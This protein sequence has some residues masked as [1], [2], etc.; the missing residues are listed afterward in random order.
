MRVQLEGAGGGQVGP[1]AILALW[2]W[3]GA[4][5]LLLGGEEEYPPHS[6]AV[7]LHELM[8]KRS[9]KTV[10]HMLCLCGHYD[11]ALNKTSMV[12]EMPHIRCSGMGR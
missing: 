11:F 2:L 5:T 10:P 9:L 12:C 7:H 3:V 6:V 8:D 1:T 4:F